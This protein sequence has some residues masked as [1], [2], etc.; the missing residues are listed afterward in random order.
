M[1]SSKKSGTKGKSETSRLLNELIEKSI[2]SARSDRAKADALY[3][4]ALTQLVNKQETHQ[5]IGIQIAKYVEASQ[6]S[7]EQIVKLISILAKE[8]PVTDDFS[9]EDKEEIY[10]TLKRD[11][12]NNA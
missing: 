5:N 1:S 2:N 11:L 9:A 7:N 8:T 12:D 10:E 6:R 4:D 3:T